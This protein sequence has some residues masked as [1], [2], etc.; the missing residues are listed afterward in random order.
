[1]VDLGGDALSRSRYGLTD[2]SES[3]LIHYQHSHVGYAR[4]ERDD[5]S[6]SCVTP[7][8]VLESNS[9]A[10]ACKWLI[11]CRRARS[12]CELFSRIFSEDR[13]F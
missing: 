12:P 7:F 4:E 6:A 2:E 3:T 5:F 10:E 13:Q 9:P 11:C 8:A 1:M